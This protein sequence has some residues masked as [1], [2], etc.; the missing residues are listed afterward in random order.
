M[1]TI[2]KII[3]TIYSYVGT[4]AAVTIFLAV[5]FGIVL[6]FIPKKKR[7]L[8]HKAASVARTIFQFLHALW[9][10]L[11]ASSGATYVVNKWTTADSILPA[12]DAIKGIALVSLIGWIAASLSYAIFLRIRRASTSA[13]DQ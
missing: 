10:A 1:E 3:R 6:V 11:F 2:E 9:F 5:L 4:A 13:N 12:A 8:K 7:D